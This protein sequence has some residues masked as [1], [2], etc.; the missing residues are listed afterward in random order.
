M[1]QR[2]FDKE[3][4]F[5]SKFAVMSDQTKGRAT[6]EEP[7]PLR[8]EFQRDRD[9]I[10]HCKSFRRLKN[11]TQVFLMPEGDHYR[12]RLTH[13]LDV[14]QIARSIARFLDLNE[15]LAEAIALGHDLGHPPFGHIGERTLDRLT[16]GHFSHNEQSLRLADVLEKD[17]AGLNLTMEVRD[18]ILQ[19]R[20]DGK[21]ATLEGKAVSFAD[22][23]AYINHDIDDS[24]RAGILKIEQLPKD[25]VKTLGKTARER[26]NNMI[27]AVVEQSTNK[28]VLD[29]RR[30]QKD[31]MGEL[32]QFMFKNIYTQ[33]NGNR[34]DIVVDRMLE[35]LYNFYF[36]KPELM[37]KFFADLL[38]KYPRYRVVCDYVSGM[39]D[40]YAIQ[41][42]RNIFTP[43]SWV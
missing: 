20:T 34:E 25:A 28:P 15:D 19:H 36:D 43:S 39:S 40:S 4:Q 30:E 24:I 12:T 5:L 16:G 32:R 2:T 33:E 1:K 13:T 37:P 35:L 31:A 9:R 7:C 23:I 27:V 22:K 6:Y 17:G 11:K 38:K 21:P 3:R 18:G 41:T 42:F 29:M 26:I 8:T 14:C 10:L